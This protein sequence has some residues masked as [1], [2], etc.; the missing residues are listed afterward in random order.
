MTNSKNIE[1]VSVSKVV[2]I[3]KRPLVKNIN[4]GN[5]CIYKHEREVVG[6]NDTAIIVVEDSKGNTLRERTYEGKAFHKAL[7]TIE[8]I[9]KS[10]DVVEF[11]VIRC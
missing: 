7:R 4:S 6:P 3:R 2:K 8:K 11:T 1:I 5:V 10:G 9:T